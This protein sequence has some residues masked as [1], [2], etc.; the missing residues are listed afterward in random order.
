MSAEMGRGWAIDPLAGPTGRP[1]YSDGGQ[2]AGSARNLAQRNLNSF[3]ERARKPLATAASP[4]FVIVTHP[5]EGRRV[6]CLPSRGVLTGSRVGD[7][8]LEG[9]GVSAA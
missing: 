7:Q 8:H 5:A 6:A 1:S 2:P 3:P 9:S 4:T